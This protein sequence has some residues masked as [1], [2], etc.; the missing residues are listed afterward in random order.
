MPNE[1]KWLN[2]ILINSF[3]NFAIIRYLQQLSWHFGDELSKTCRDNKHQSSKPKV[4]G[5]GLHRPPRQQT[6]RQHYRYSKN[7][8]GKPRTQ[9]NFSRKQ[10]GNWKLLENPQSKVSALNIPT[11]VQKGVRA[12]QIK[13]FRAYCEKLRQKNW[14]KNSQIQSSQHYSTNVTP[15]E[16]VLRNSE[17]QMLLITTHQNIG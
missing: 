5:P 17:A 1:V 11:S 9:S 16:K 14:G 6:Y 4:S 15:Q 7:E 13:N 10:G 12:G 8:Q 3:N 2:L